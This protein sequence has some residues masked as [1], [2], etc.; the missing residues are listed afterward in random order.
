MRNHWK[1]K[2]VLICCQYKNCSL[3]QKYSNCSRLKNLLPT[4]AFC[5]S[6]KIVIMDLLGELQRAEFKEA[7]D[8]FDKVNGKNSCEIPCILFCLQVC[9]VAWLW[10][11]NINIG[12]TKPVTRFEGNYDI[13]W[14]G[15]IPSWQKLGTFTKWRDSNNWS[16]QNVNCKRYSLLNKMGFFQKNQVNFWHRKM[17]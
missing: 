8:E 15:G 14:N 11:W 1:K 12:C 2:K 5:L 16:Y 10:L 7:F 9:I 3:F 13:V 4:T 17:I 6:K